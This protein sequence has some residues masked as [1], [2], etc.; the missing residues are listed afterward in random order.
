[1]FDLII[2]ILAIE[3][4]IIGQI[5]IIVGIVRFFKNK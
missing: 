1:M 3:L 2:K 4:F 5:F